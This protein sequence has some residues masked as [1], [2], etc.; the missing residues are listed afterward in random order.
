MWNPN[1]I[2]RVRPNVVKPRLLYFAVE[3]GY[4]SETD[5]DKFF[6]RWREYEYPTL[7]LRG[8]VQDIDL[9]ILTQLND[10]EINK[11]RLGKALP[12]RVLAAAQRVV[13]NLGG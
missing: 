2:K 6:E 5:Y 7:T 13:V 3:N 12:D 9:D 11:L 1:N 8:G 10:T 4:L